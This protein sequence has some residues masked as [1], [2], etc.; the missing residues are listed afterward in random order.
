MTTRRPR[1]ERQNQ[2]DVE[3]PPGVPVDAYGGP[4]VDPTRNVL[5]HVAAAVLRIDD[6]AELRAQLVDEKI[7]RMEREWVHQDKFAILRAEH[8]KEIRHMESERVN[9]IRSVDVQNAAATAAQ[10]LSAVTTLATTAQATAE[11][12]RNQVAATAAA[13]ASQTER[14]MNPVVERIALLEK[15]QYTGAGKAGVADP[16]YDR[17]TTAVEALSKM[18]SVGAGER[19]GISGAWAAL[20]GFVSL[21]GGLL[22]IG[23]VMY[24]VAQR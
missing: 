11:T 2:D 10:L 21:V 22:G 17:L 9:S 23:G 13:V 12:L 4:T 18:Q 14:V 7:Y 5:G 16:L 6:M 8:S 19:R 24:A 15:A 20:L 1:R 3:A